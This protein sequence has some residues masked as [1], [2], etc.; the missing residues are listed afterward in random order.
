[1]IRKTSKGTYIITVQVEVSEETMNGILSSSE[2]NA[3]YRLYH[4]I[5]ARINLMHAMHIIHN[6]KQEK[7]S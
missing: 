2:S 1:M 7:S 3:A 5:V 4:A 6:L